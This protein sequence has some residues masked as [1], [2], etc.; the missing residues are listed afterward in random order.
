M[1]PEI[2]VNTFKYCLFKYSIGNTVGVMRI[3]SGGITEI[4]WG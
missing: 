1:P 3:L 2:I 4:G